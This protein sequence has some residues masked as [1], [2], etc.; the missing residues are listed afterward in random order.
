[1]SRA[2]EVFTIVAG[3]VAV[4]LLGSAM[5]LAGAIARSGLVTIQIDDRREG[6]ALYLPV[7]G[8]VVESGLAVLP[9]LARHHEVRR[10]LR[11][12]RAE[13]EEWEPFLRQVARVLDEAP[14][15][16]FVEA[17]DRGERVRI[18]KRGRTIRVEV[19]GGDGERVRL[20]VPSRLVRRTIVSVLG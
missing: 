14:D 11:Q 4:L 13:I 16:T 5:L 20:S 7:P 10:E 2:G 6:F 12:V 17:Y 8:F 19:D 3:S 9:R 15:C 18:I 1:M